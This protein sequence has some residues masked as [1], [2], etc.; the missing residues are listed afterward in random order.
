MPR[1]VEVEITSRGKTLY[2]VLAHAPAVLPDEDSETVD[3]TSF[4]DE[5]YTLVARNIQA[6]DA[7]DAIRQQIARSYGPLA[8]APRTFVAVPARSWNPQ[9]VAIETQT[10]VKIGAAIE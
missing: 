6:R 3:V 7:E 10:V 2:H 1:Q 5:T 8:T 4:E 9:V